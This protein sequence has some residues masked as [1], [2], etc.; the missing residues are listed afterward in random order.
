[1]SCN[2]L[3]RRKDSASLAGLKV[4]SDKA[5]TDEFICKFLGWRRV[6]S[7]VLGP[8]GVFDNWPDWLRVCACHLWVTDRRRQAVPSGGW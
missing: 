8:T 4:D 1:M 2:E 5:E 7:R 3:G 6:R